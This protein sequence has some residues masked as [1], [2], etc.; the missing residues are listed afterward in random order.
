MK[1]LTRGIADLAAQIE[2]DRAAQL[3]GL[4]LEVVVDLALQVVLQREVD[5]D[6]RGEQRK[7]EH[8]GVEQRDPPA[9]RQRRVQ[10]DVARSAARRAGTTTGA[11]AHRDRRPGSPGSSPRDLRAHSRNT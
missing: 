11:D 3:A 6:V 1:T 9:Q 4:I 10:Q 7:P 2:I 5:R 8:G